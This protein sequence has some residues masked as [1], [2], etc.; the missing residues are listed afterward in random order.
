MCKTSET[1]WSCLTCD[2]V[3]IDE[4]QAH[5]HRAFHPIQATY[6]GP[7]EERDRRR[8]KF[9][10]PPIGRCYNCGKEFWD[11]D[12]WA[13]HEIRI[14]S[15]PK[16]T[17]HMAYYGQKQRRALPG[18]DFQE[19]YLTGPAH[20]IRHESLAPEPITHMETL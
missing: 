10:V 18:L 12:A 3:T 14:P 8:V 2:F 13:S 1:V 9:H 15:C 6:T 7:P 17:P 20:R 19:E 16:P 4:H 5:H 11:K